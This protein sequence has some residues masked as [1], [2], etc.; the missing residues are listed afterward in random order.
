MPEIKITVCSAPERIEIYQL[1]GVWEDKKFFKKPKVILKVDTKGNILQ[2]VD[3]NA[4]SEREKPEGN[5][6]EHRD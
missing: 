6:T 2:K 4:V 1:I 5:K 3:H